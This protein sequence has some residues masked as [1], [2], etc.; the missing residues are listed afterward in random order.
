M[1]TNILISHIEKHLGK[2]SSSWTV[3]DDNEH[4]QIIKFLNNPQKKVSTFLTLGLSHH[5]LSMPS[6]K[7]CR[8]ELL[9]SVYDKFN[10]EDVASMLIMFSKLIIS[11]HKA[12]LRGGIEKIGKS[13][14]PNV[15]TSYLFA[16]VPF[17]FAETFD[18]LKET[19]PPVM[20]PLLIPL[21]STEVNYISMNGRESFEKMF[22]EKDPDIFDLNRLPFV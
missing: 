19:N 7:E 12:V 22:E 2:I 5:L 17:I 11:S 18:L 16:S 14:L 6:G 21:H 8:Q 1:N 4:I 13:I 20:F 9:F 15:K 10:S 3:K